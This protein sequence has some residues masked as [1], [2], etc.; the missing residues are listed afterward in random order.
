MK[1]CTGCQVEKPESD[2]RVIKRPR[3]V[4]KIKTG[5]FYDYCMTICRDCESSGAKKRNKKNREFYT[6]NRK[7]KSTVWER[8]GYASK[9]A[10][11]KYHKEYYKKN[12]DKISQAKKDDKWTYRLQHAKLRAKEKGLEFNL[13]REFLESIYVQFCPILGT[14]LS[15]GGT[16]RIVPESATID[17]IDNSKGYTTDN[18]Q[19]LS[20]K[21][22]RMK[23]DA[24]HD[25]LKAFANYILGTLG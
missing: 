7:S 9:E 21:A 14:E 3:V 20:Y 23:S 24:T 25:E 5:E 10:Y 12:K 2:F 6:R 15:Y 13:T 1:K 19:I 16:G 18:V 4:N 17:R 8:S 22:N 11:Y